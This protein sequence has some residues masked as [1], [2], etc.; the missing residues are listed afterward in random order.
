MMEK[1]DA[2]VMSFFILAATGFLIMLLYTYDNPEH[3][4]YWA[5]GK[6]GVSKI[7]KDT[8]E[9]FKFTP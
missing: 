8:C 5:C 3:H 1:T 7:T 9:C 4:C 2:F 6:T